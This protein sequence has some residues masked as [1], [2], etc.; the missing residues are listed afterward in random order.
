[1]SNQNSDHEDRFRHLRFLTIAQVC[2]LTGYS[3]QHIY[4]LMRAGTF[5]QRRRLGGNRVGVRLVDFEAWVA[6][7]EVVETFEEDFAEA[8]ASRPDSKP[9][10]SPWIS[11]P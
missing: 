9:R 6:S 1:M 2:E 7:R 10:S 3:V 5:P 4:R 11:S 8:P